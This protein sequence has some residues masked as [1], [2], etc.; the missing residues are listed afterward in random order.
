MWGL[1][2]IE[3][4]EYWD[5]EPEYAPHAYQSGTGYRDG[6]GCTITHGFLNYEA[7]CSKFHEL[8]QRVG[9]K[10]VRADGTV[11]G[12]LLGAQMWGRTRTWT[13]DVSGAAPTAPA[14]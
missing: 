7:A 5:G 3:I 6:A 12:R 4:A 9:E 14:H 2:D 10:Y 1:R 11:G 8:Q 13:T